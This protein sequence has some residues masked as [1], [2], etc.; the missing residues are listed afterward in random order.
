[1]RKYA[2]LFLN[3]EPF[4]V[5]LLT[6]SYPESDDIVELDPKTKHKDLKNERLDNTGKV[7]QTFKTKYGKK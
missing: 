4:T 6:A 2:K 7:P 1:M 5:T 3:K